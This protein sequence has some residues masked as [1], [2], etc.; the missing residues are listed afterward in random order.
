M[1]ATAGGGL[2]ASAAVNPP[3]N[4]YYELQIFHMKT[5]PQMQRAN[6]FFGKYYVPAATKL[7][8]PPVGFFS[9]VIGEQSPYLMM[10]VSHPNLESVDTFNQ[11]LDGNAEYRKGFEAYLSGEAPYLRR[12]SRLLKAFDSIPVLQVPPAKAGRIFEMRTYESPTSIT[13]ARKIKMFG[14]GEIA[15]FRRLGMF[16]VFFGRTIFGPNIPN[17]CYMLAFDDLAHREKLWK[18][19]GADPEWNKMKALPGLS[20]PEI[21][22]NISN[23]IL[24]PASYSQ[25]Q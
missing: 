3:K 5:G 15:I 13:L 16:P 20:D 2:L 17:L 14:D 7:G 4:Q 22:S 8:A 1:S 25:V 21:V 18:D 10:L 24:R 6:D 9:P 12:E 11:K 19:F 23:M